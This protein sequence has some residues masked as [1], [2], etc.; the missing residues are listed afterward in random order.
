MFWNLWCEKVK[1][2]CP[3]DSGTSRSETSV[4]TSTT[5]SS[6]YLV[7]KKVVSLNGIKQSI[8]LACPALAEEKNLSFGA[9]V[10][11]NRFGSGI[12]EGCGTGLYLTFDDYIVPRRFSSTIF[13]STSSNLS[14]DC[15]SIDY[16]EIAETAVLLW[17]YYGLTTNRK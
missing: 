1:F 7:D 2:L 17:E 6:L 13:R 3:G 12:L 14:I 8:E 11:V 5:G 4:A 15:G 9:S 10:Q 16:E